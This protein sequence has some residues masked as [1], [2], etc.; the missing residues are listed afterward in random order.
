MRHAVLFSGVDVTARGI[1]AQRTSKTRLGQFGLC[2]PRRA[3]AKTKRKRTQPTYP[4]LRNADYLRWSCCKRICALRA[5]PWP[6]RDAA[7]DQAS[8]PAAE[9]MA[10]TTQ[11]RARDADAI[12]LTE[13]ASPEKK[14]K[15]A[16]D[17]AVDVDQTTQRDLEYAREIGALD[18]RAILLSVDIDASEDLIRRLETEVARLEAAKDATDE[19]GLM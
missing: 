15:V 3:S 17:A 14:H 6:Q 19:A 8:Q 7:A 4:S 18:A 13:D 10:E 5:T 2:R 16:T 9:G 11:K 1:D 12:D